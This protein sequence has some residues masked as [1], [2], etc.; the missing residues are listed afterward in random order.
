M[1]IDDTMANLKVLV[2]MLNV[3]GY[4]IRTFSNPLLAYKSATIKKPDL[5]LLDID[6]PEMNGYD[7][8]KLFKDDDKLKAI[9]IIFISALVDTNNIIMG[10]NAGGVDYITK[11]FQWQEVI[12]RV[13]TQLEIL[14]GK[15]EM[16]LILSKTFVGSIQI[17]ADILSTTKP[18]VFHYAVRLKHIMKHMAAELNLGDRWIYEITGML[19]ML[20]YVVFPDDKI[21]Q[22]VKGHPEAITHKDRI[23]ASEFTID[24]ISK[25]PRLDPIVDIVKHSREPVLVTRLEKPLPSWSQVESG[26]NMLS[27]VLTYLEL[28]TVTKLQS[29]VFEHIRRMTTAFHP[30]LIEALEKVEFRKLDIGE[31][32]THILQLRPGM[33]LSQD[34]VTTDEVLLLKA[35]TSL[36]ESLITLIQG[37]QRHVEIKEPVYVWNRNEAH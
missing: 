10:F 17:M 7:L 13:N 28:S 31:R 37:Y 36:T 19:Y 4:S 24:L 35:N 29:Q 2:N 16:E 3:K 11:P 34:V 8:C 6:M 21:Q 22:Y 1:I 20:G 30:T 5:I 27:L 9:P 15:R 14:K 32:E 25:I 26:A 12:A 18:D 33:V 23:E